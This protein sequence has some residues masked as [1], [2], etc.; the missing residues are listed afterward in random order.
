[1]NQRTLWITCLLSLAAMF[2]VPAL[3]VAKPPEGIRLDVAVGYDGFVQLGRINPVAVTME[4]NSATL[5]LSG[6]LVLTFNEVEYVTPLELPTPSKKRFFLYFPC[7]AWPP[8]LNLTVRT[9]AYTEQFGLNALYKT[10]ESDDFSILVLSQQSGSLGAVNQ[11]PGVKLYRDVYRDT[12]TQVGSSVTNV[13][14]ANL[15]EIDSNPKYFSRADAVVLADIDYQ[16]VTQQLAE[17]LAA[18]VSGGTK[19][20][21]SLGL[22]GA[23][24]AGS[25]LATLC[26]L[27]PTGT[28]QLADLGSFGQH[29][30]IKTGGAQATFAIGN[31]V[32]GAVIR[33]SAGNF[34]AVI[35][36]QRGSGTV[37]A[38][39]FDV[40]AVPFKLNPALGP[41]FIDNGLRV[42]DSVAV[43]GWF[44]HPEYVS[45]VLTKFRE[46]RPITPYFVFL[47]LISYVALVGPLNFFV[48]S[49]LKR[50]TLVWT[51]IPL[52]ILAFGY[53]GLSTGYLY[54]GSDN[55]TSYFQ[56]LH[57]YPNTDYVP[58][59]TV[60]LVFTAERTNYKLQV[61]DAS[62]FMYPDL[63]VTEISPFGGGG[64]RVRGI[65][66]GRIDN[67]SVPSVT[68]TQ[69][70]WTTKQYYYQGYLSLPVKLNTQL[71]ATRAARG[72][73]QVDGS[74]TLDL[75]F[76][77]YNA[78]LYDGQ[79]SSSLGNIPRQGTF[80]LW[81]QLPET[82]GG[83]S[84]DNYI[85]NARAELAS[86]QQEASRV[87]QRYR[88]EVLLVGFT[89]QIEAQAKFDR[90][91]NEHRL[92]MVVLHLPYQ[93]I[94]ADQGKPEVVR[95]RLVGGAGFEIRNE[96]YSGSSFDMDAL[97]YRLQTN[98]YIDACYEIAGELDQDSHLL[99]HLNASD[100]GSAQPL[101]DL[102]VLLRPAVWDGQRWR[103]LNMRREEMVI[104]IPL[105]SVLDENRQV[106]V[107]FKSAGD[108][109][110]QLPWADAY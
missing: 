27:Q 37:T 80:Q 89:E 55:V 23:G 26:P 68:A 29:Y 20:F 108:F 56:E 91:H 100:A 71:T 65:F 82:G 98:A 61:P 49:R 4:N 15:D 106:H 36:M 38:M 69:G 18:S 83:L 59:Q 93:P 34:P 11:I 9:K 45:K 50:R 33:E 73:S 28:A 67:S 5:N 17:S 96:N 44:I 88:D 41:L 54:R 57:I 60:M 2:A 51:T 10:I 105:A 40:T 58:Y 24:V 94:I 86:Y 87:G 62:A 31:P 3:A 6:D 102:N 7:D 39:A 79:A 42:E 63:P 64:S 46:G 110:M 97:Q 107:R 25:P 74:V 104:D 72:L 92:T 14:Y 30:G 90:P 8:N 70:Q 47:F 21:F 12:T 99:L 52:I 81:G 76:D 95:S 16:Q 1:M 109:L 84:A 78:Y 32:P 77:L 48:L 35:S 101:K 85:V 66:G 19:L 53:L 13:Y 22:N 75:P 103:E 43:T